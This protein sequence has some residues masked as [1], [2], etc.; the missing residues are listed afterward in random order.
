MTMRHVV[1]AG[2]IIFSAAILGGG[3]APSVLAAPPHQVSFSKDVQPILQKN[4]ATCH[5]VGGKG[6][7]ASGMLLMTYEGVM[8]G[9]Q[10]GPMIVPY[11]PDESNLIRMIDWKVDATIRMPHEGKQLSAADRS[12][13]R[14][15][16]REGAQDN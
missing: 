12:M 1:G 4:C 7:Q 16:V 5:D 10:F 13:I 14:T 2:V 8:K 9:T 15:W 3:V 6:H 11:A